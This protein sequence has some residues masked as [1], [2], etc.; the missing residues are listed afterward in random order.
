[1]RIEPG[2]DCRSVSWRQQTDRRHVLA[3]ITFWL[4]AQTTLNVAPAMRNDLRVAE[5]VG[6]TAVSI[7]AM[8]S[9]IFIVVAGE[10]ADQFGRM[11][12]TNLGLALNIIGSQLIAVSPAGT[13]TFFDDRARRPGDFGRVHHAGNARPD[14]GLLRRR[15]SSARAELL[16]DRFVGRLGSERAVRRVRRLDLGMAMDLLDVQPRSR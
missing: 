15:G 1:V 5:S 11:K 6:N 10:R 12:F 2:H 13:A 14:E 3:V 16:V 4:F 7:T 8:F 9:G